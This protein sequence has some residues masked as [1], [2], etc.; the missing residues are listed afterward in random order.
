[1]KESNER[2]ARKVQISPDMLKSMKQFFGPDKHHHNK[3]AATKIS[4][5]LH[6][7]K[8]VYDALAELEA[9]E[10]ERKTLIANSTKPLPKTLDELIRQRDAVREQNRRIREGEAERKAKKEPRPD[11]SGAA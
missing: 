4:A 2:T 7:E 8:P 3:E 11:E 9:A 6:T 1:L 5:F 10:A